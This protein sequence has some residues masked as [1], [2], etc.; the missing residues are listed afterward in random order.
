MQLRV[1]LANAIIHPAPAQIIQVI[2]LVHRIIIPTT[3]IIPITIIIQIPPPLT[4]QVLI[5]FLTRM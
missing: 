3:L 5:Q 1:Q 2:A 4:V